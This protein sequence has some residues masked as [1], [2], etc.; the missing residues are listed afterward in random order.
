[1]STRAR[2]SKRFAARSAEARAAASVPW[3]LPRWVDVAVLA[4]ILVTLASW[5]W[6]KW[7]DVLVDFGHELYIPWQL[8]E[9]RVLYR[10]IVYFM[11]PLSQYL[12]ALLFRIFGV[13]FTTLI[14]ANLAILA[15]MTAA[16]RSLF[17]RALG[18][19]A[20]VLAGAVFLCV[21]GFG[22]YV[23]L[24]N[25]NYVTPYLHEQSHGVALGLLLLVLLDRA[26][27][28]P[29]IAVVAAAGATLGLTCLTK[30]ES[31]VPALAA[32]ATAG[33][34]VLVARRPATAVAVRT[35][36][37]FL[38]AAV[39]PV[40]A[41]LLLLRTQMPWPT[42]AR[43]VVGNWVY[44][45]DRSLI[46]ADPFYAK[47]VGVD[48]VR[49]QLTEILIAAA[50]VLLF[51]AFALGLERALRGRGRGP[52]VAAGAL[53]AVALAMGTGY[54]SWVQIARPLPIFCAATA[55]AYLWQCWRRRSDEAGAASR[56]ILAVWSVFALASLAKMILR[57]R[58]EH[59]GF[60]LAM[61][62]TLL[63][64]A[65]LVFVVPRLLAARGGG[66]GGE[67]WQAVALAAVAVGTG[68]LLRLSG[69]HY[70]VRTVPVGSGGDRLYTFD[71]RHPRLG[72]A[73]GRFLA[74]L[75][76]LQ[77][78]TSSGGTLVVLPDGVLLNYLL[79]RTNPT[80]YYL[81]TPW[82]MRAFG[83]EEA[84]LARIAPTMPE[85]VAI[86]RIDMSEFGSSYFGDPGYGDRVHA[87]LAQDY[88]RAA[89]V[90][91]EVAGQPW[92][93]IYRRRR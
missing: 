47:Y 44:I 75:D 32:A 85:H 61:P 3:R 31:F 33:A 79:R 69:F 27:R 29:A 25:Y 93:T 87:W 62:G 74:A 82:E 84:V 55:V 76:T 20:G 22:H 24:G 53:T 26:V 66:R 57:A 50:W 83:G 72:V 41:A 37:V 70:E 6:R 68:W 35:S 45:F 13:S 1:M 5:T 91:P 48:G 88:D 8:A 17:A 9:G 43:G 60:A 80:P 19:P 7:G 81:I 21:F 49:E 77:K 40:A 46:L 86:A 56:F 64:V 12:N 4:A 10:D 90:G 67:A 65:V 54:V 34:I 73:T 59:Y 18:R 28:R 51:A 89:T 63:L 2:S 14:V 38:G 52:A 16:I 92:M 42:A 36:A 11:G 39:L 78:E 23:R 30:A 58:I 71:P 15:G